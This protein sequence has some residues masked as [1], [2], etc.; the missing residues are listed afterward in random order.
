MSTR[1]WILLALNALTWG[2]SFL[3]IKLVVAGTTPL[4]LTFGRCALGAV[5]MWLYIWLRQTPAIISGRQGL[6]YHRS[7]RMGLLIVALMT[8]IPF[9]IFAWAETHI[10]SGLAGIANASTPV[11]STLLAM[12][13]DHDHRGSPMRW[14]G[15]TLGF[16]G[17]AILL[18]AEGATGSAADTLALASLTVAAFC[19]SIGGITTRVRLRQIDS[20]RVAAWSSTIPA[21]IFAVPAIYSLHGHLPPTNALLALLALGV[22]PTGIGLLLYY[23]L[24][25]MVGAS[26]AAMVT[27]VM[28]PLAVAYGA[29]FLSESVT[30]IMVASMI[31]ILLG[32]FIGSRE[33]GGPVEIEGV[34]PAS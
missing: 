4:M 32:V 33:W 16:A 27:Y 34:T 25:E 8:G 14:F 21:F 18:V 5:V 2:S 10:T 23:K 17:V 7:E 13:W 31:V 26:R 22:V 3:F 15:V 6:E 20:A 19:Y 12:R 9:T 29:I 24:L 30:I 1:A 11:W 28:P